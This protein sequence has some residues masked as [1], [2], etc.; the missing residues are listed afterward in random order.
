MHKTNAAK[1]KDFVMY[2]WVVLV[3]CLHQVT[4]STKLA[5]FALRYTSH[6]DLAL[7]LDLVTAI[8]TQ[9]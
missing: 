1:R 6:L 5:T 4:Y 9:L 8:E 2:P 7:A 3:I